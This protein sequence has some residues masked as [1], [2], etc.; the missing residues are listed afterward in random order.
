MRP[1]LTALLLAAVL[2]LAQAGER[3]APAN[4]VLRCA[5]CHGMDG[6]G[7]EK[8]GIPPFPGLVDA[9]Y[10]DAEGRRYLMHVP[11]V[12][13]SSLSDAEIAAVMNYIN[14]RWGQPG[15]EVQPFSASEVGQL[16]GEPVRDLVA[17]RRGIVARLQAQGV[18]VAAYPWP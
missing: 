9:F 6:S 10:M 8:A 2:P 17:L 12:V 18:A 11:G 14:R 7:L 1:L 15:R 5:G 4:Y 13:A 3:S 16:R